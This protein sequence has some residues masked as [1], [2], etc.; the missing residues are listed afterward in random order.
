[1]QKELTRRQ[2][3]QYKKAEEAEKREAAM[4]SKP[5]QGIGPVSTLQMTTRSMVRNPEM[6]EMQTTRF[7]GSTVNMANMNMNQTAT[8]Q[9]NSMESIN[10]NSPRQNFNLGGS[11]RNLAAGEQMP[12]NN[13][14]RRALATGSSSSSTNSLFQRGS[15]RNLARND[16]G[17]G[18]S[19]TMF[20]ARQQRLRTVDPIE[21]ER[22]LQTL[23]RDRPI[24]Q[25][26]PNIS[27][28]Q[29]V[30]FRGAAFRKALDR[31]Q[32]LGRGHAMPRGDYMALAEAGGMRYPNVR[33]A[34]TAAIKKHKR[35]LIIGGAVAGGLAI[36]GGSIY[37]AVK[38][39][40]KHKQKLE[41]YLPNTQKEKETAFEKNFEALKKRI[42][43]GN[44]EIKA[45]A[46]QYDKPTGVFE[47]M[48]NGTASS[49]DYMG[50]GG[51]GGSSSG[52][53][54]GNYQKAYQLANRALGGK[55]KYRKKR[56]AKKPS[57]G[58]KGARKTRSGRV[59]KRRRS[60]KR[61]NKRAGK[62][63]R[64]S[65]KRRSKKKAF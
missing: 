5:I 6:P 55:K 28:D 49:G 27:D 33:Q 11:F 24:T 20:D 48:H 37:S 65:K 64:Y 63:K 51:G 21:L 2:L 4:F 3:A 1:M 38:D 61:I 16:A 29:Q 30:R 25:S 15:N 26:T 41:D 7:R 62:A 17:S 10:L 13:L 18:S 60:S 46:M 40:E 22:R 59:T 42:V 12:L 14:G 34:F 44:E 9:H 53:G 8:P 57:A 35:K 54:Y 32:L 56:R 19:N 23:T 50:G 58:K 31:V 45:K 52:G 43:K 47:K 36:L 39:T